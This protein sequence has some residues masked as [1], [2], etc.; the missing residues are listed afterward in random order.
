[1]GLGI[2]TAIKTLLRRHFPPFEPYIKILS[3]DGC[4][5]EFFYGTSLAKEWYD[6]IVP[7]VRAELDWITHNIDLRDQKILDGGAHHGL[8]SVFFG[9][10]SRRSG[11]VVS[12]DPVEAN[13]ALVQVNMRLNC[14]QPRIQHCAISDADGSVLFSYESN[15]EIVS[16]WGQVKQSKRLPSIMPDATLVKLDVE[17]AE[18]L[19]LPD[20]IDEMPHVKAWVVEIHPSSRRNPENLIDLF[21]EREYELYWI[22]RQD[23]LVRAY[24]SPIAWKE[25]AT[26]F[27]IRRS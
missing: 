8:Y 18:F 27:A 16:R 23:A 3:F 11:D 21:R 22:N 7:F 4:S 24:S 1:M 10:A 12:V 5:F 25:P 9:V 6:P 13:C 26:V 20:Q 14:L 15:G 19:I 2:R 17:G